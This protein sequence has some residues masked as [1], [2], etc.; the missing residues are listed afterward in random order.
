MVCVNQLCNKIE[1]LLRM[2]ASQPN[3]NYKILIWK[4]QKQNYDVS[5]WL[6]SI[7][8]MDKVFFKSV[9]FAGLSKLNQRYPSWNYNY[10][11]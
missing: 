11:Y 4:E 3:I 9:K 6:K 10:N 5:I 2:V 1:I 8:F 7:F